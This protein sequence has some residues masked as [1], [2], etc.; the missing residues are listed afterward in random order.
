MTTHE[1][2]FGL[3]TPAFVTV[4]ESGQLLERRRRH[5]QHHRGGRPRRMPS[6]STRS[7]SASTTG[8]NSW[9]PPVT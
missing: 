7:T 3:D 8:L 4:D 1:F 2:E 6:E 9:T 5:P